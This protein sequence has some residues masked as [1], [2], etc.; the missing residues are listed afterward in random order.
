MGMFAIADS[1]DQSNFSIHS[2]N[3]L[4]RLQANKKE[5]LDTVKPFE[6]QFLDLDLSCFVQPFIPAAGVMDDISPMV[7]HV[8]AKSWDEQ[9][10]PGLVEGAALRAGVERVY[11]WSHS[12]E[13]PKLPMTDSQLSGEKPLLCECSCCV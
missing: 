12:A 13:E 10:L 1:F 2:F 6:E 5:E 4:M 11:A 9:N 7:I 8:L 3:F